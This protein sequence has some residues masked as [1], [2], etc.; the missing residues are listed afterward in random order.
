[1]DMQGVTSENV[2]RVGYDSSTRTMRVEFKSGG[3]Y[4]YLDVS[5]DLYRRMLQPHPWRDIGE[6]VKAHR[7]IP[8]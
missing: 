8:R 5:P 2:A 7:F 1:M 3:T 4:D 6:H